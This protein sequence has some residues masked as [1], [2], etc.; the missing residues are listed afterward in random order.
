MPHVILQDV[1]GT[2]FPDAIY[3]RLEAVLR[4]CYM[5]AE[6]EDSVKAVG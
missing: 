6:A 5:I 3:M 2:P 4:D 1:L